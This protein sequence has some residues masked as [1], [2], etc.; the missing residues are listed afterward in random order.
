L[1]QSRIRPPENEAIEVLI[2]V[3]GMSVSF[4]RE[5]DL[6]VMTMCGVMTLRGATAARDA[7]QG[8]LTEEDARAVVV[9]MREAIPLFGTEGW[10]S[11]P[12]IGAVNQSGPPVALVVTPRYEQPLRAYCRA[13][14]E[15]GCVRAPFIGLHGAVAWAGQCL[16]HWPHRPCRSTRR[17]PVAPV[18]LD[19]QSQRPAQTAHTL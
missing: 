10:R 9:D 13:M 2:S 18:V 6:L 11:L 1:Q 8:Q 16:E 17:V 12:T 15:R 7:L 19:W 14:A 3:E 4:R 5:A